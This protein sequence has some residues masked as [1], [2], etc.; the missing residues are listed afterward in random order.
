MY[1]LMRVCVAA[2]AML[3]LLVGAGFAAADGPVEPPEVVAELHPGESL[4]IEKEV[5]T[6]PIPP[7]VDVCLLEDE[8]G[9]FWDDIWNLQSGTTASDIYDHI[10]AEAPEAHFAVAGFRD[11][12]VWPHG[13][14]GDHVYR[15]LS[16]MSSIKQDWLNG[17][18]ALTAGGGADGP[19]AQYDAI[20]AATGPGVFID[21]TEG[22]QDNCGW[23]DDPDVT[24]VLV[25]A[26]DAPFHLP[27]P[28]KPHVNT[29]A[30]T[31]AAL[32]AQEIV[33]IGLKA[34]GA[35]GEL[36]ALAA[37]TGGSVQPLCPSGA[38][39]AEAI[40][41]ALEEL[42]TDVWWEADC[43]PELWVD[44]SPPVHTDVPGDTT[45]WFE[46]TI[47]VANDAVP[48]EYSC[49]VRFIANKYPDEGTEIGEQTIRITVLDGRMTGGGSVFTEDGTRVTHGFELHCPS[50]FEPNNLE[51]NWGKGDRFHM[52]S[53][54]A[55]I[56]SDDPSLDESPP[57]AGFDTFWGMGTGRYNGESGA[58]IH[59]RFTDDGEP[60]KND[61]AA[62]W[63][64]D[65]GGNVV[66]TVSG[67]LDRGNHQAHAK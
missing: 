43:D 2:A 3:A 22:E 36:D 21:P 15:L 49:T 28:G 23:R 50:V 1:R 47:G 62:I 44:L 9:S 4:V 6:P 30:S 66:L 18:A 7:N 27:G 56:C 31:L 46:E 58:I 13:G 14:P 65:A 45:V 41:A 32:Q 20:V 16:G 51:V 55:A 37:A 5:T 42:T 61:T 24:R 38:D 53:L 8:T 29:Q 17:I 11:Y 35:G 40:I 57:A 26:T 59:F 33:V 39:I 60:G 34:P 64:Q 54:D 19:E 48:G 63:I 12:P 10:V 67:I 25:A 52:E